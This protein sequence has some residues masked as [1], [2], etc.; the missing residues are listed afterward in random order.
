MINKCLDL[1]KTNSCP[2]KI[3]PIK[4]NKNY[5]IYNNTCDI[6]DLKE[7]GQVKS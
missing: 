4:P 7:I 2:Y 1:Q 5:H 6:E 3:D